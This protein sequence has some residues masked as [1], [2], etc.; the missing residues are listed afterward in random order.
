[1]Q[2]A[3]VGPPDLDSS[4]DSPTTRLRRAIEHAAHLLPAQ[5]P[6]TVF[7]H[8]NT[9]H[10]FEDLPFDEAV[11]KGGQI[12]G[13]QPYRT[14]DR[15][16]DDL[17]RGRIRFN[18]LQDVLERDLTDRGG[19]AVGCFGTRYDLRLAMLQY[20]LRTGPTAELLWYVAE[21]N[22][23]HKVRTEVSSAVRS[24]LIAETRR[25]VM[26]DFRRRGDSTPHASRGM[27]APGRRVSQR[28]HQLLDRHGEATI[29][30]W[31]DDRWESFALQALWQVCLD[32][33]RDIPPFYVPE[34]VG[35][36]HRDLLF[37]GTGADAD[38]LVHDL[39]IRLSAAFLDQ[40]FARWPLPRRD[41]GFFRAFCALYR[42]PG[43][44]PDRWMRGLD[45]ELARLEDQNMGPLE[46]ILESLAILGVAE[47]EWDRFLASTLLALRGWAGM[48]RQVEDRGDRVVRPVLGGSLVEFVAVRLIL[49]RFALAEVARQSADYH[50][51]VHELRE[52]I[53]AKLTEVEWPAG[54]EPRAFVVFQLAQIFGLSP[55][56]LSRMSPE[57]WALVMSEIENFTGVER[58][59]TFHLA[60]EQRFA[61]QT[62]DA[63]ALRAPRRVGRPPD[64]GVQ[65][66][67]CLDEREESF[68]RHLEEI[69]PGTETF[70]AAGFFG[71]PMYYR[72]AADAHF[73]A[74]CPMAVIPQRWVVEEVGDGRRQANRRRARTRKVLG[75]ASLRLHI[76][77]RTAA[78][79]AVLTGLL[80]ILASFPLVGRILFPRLT[81]RIR[82]AMGRFWRTPTRTHLH[83]ERT[84]PDP[85]APA[86]PGQEATSDPDR[87]PIG[88][89]IP[90]LADI[91]ERTLRDMGLT[92]QFSRLIVF[93]GHGSASQNNPHNSAY[94]CGACGGAAGGPNARAM[95]QLYNNPRVRSI[96]AERDLVLP[97]TTRF[98]GG[99]HNTCNDSV[100][101]F[102]IDQIPL[103]HRHDFEAAQRAIDQ[104]GQR[105]AHERCRRFM[106]A[107]LT[108]SFAAA[109]QHVEERAEDLAQTRP[110]LGHATNAIT[111]VGRREWTRGLFLDRRAFLTSYDPAQ[112]DADSSILTRILLA[113]FPVCA[114][115]NLEYY[116]S[117]VDNHGFGAGTKLPHNLA[118]L[119][120]VMD[121]AASDLRT[122]LPWQM[123]EIH[124]PIRSLFLIETT[125]ATMTRIMDR[126]PMIGRICRN[127]WVRLATLDPTTRLIQV[128]DRGSF[129]PYQVQVQ[130]IPEAASSVDWYRGWR[131]HLEFAE[132]GPSPAAVR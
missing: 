100:R 45:H 80:G 18:E 63:I 1:M 9:L 64:V 88:F 29:E 79:G 57:D 131:D 61:A 43:G 92:T 73:V 23:L 16:R 65:V 38:A 89:S 50:G 93:L 106:S 86:P 105:N 119:L 129:G 59:R 99:Y 7:I 121:G 39:L 91:G 25:W 97:D 101:F 11:K 126:N 94:N 120:G 5:G 41:E 58:R 74:L 52:H 31:D 82:G 109:K 115:I 67:C 87:Y 22:A 51:P 102:D 104:A 123:V 107:P 116:F 32:G 69:A 110:E 111:I 90:E 95:A 20:P 13:C 3:A 60:Y 53:T 132:I 62:L 98:V 54:A 81:A 37:H 124:E 46:S 44:P 85:A 78:G 114:G 30:S 47:P 19:Q 8:H 10:A 117:H 4:V 108:L 96:L 71:I 33:V 75:V 84:E 26:R 55:D 83:L 122:G 70:G 28:L 118:S 76:G 49:D 24:R 128:F 77:S 48:V 34:L 68:R 66:I 127:G 35:V 17:R 2:A 56:A 40:G 42:R 72:G 6:I 130:S 36:R 113:V 103:S 15:Y 21:A 112:D 27:N 12:F 125:P 14:E